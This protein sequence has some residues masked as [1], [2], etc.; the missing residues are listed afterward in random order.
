MSPEEIHETKVLL[1]DVLGWGVPPQYLLDLGLTPLCIA[2]CFAELK[3]RLPDNLVG[4]IEDPI[5]NPPPPIPFEPQQLHFT[6]ES[7]SPQAPS[8]SPTTPIH[9]RLTPLSPT[10][11]IPNTTSHTS[12]P[13]APNK[14]PTIDLHEIETLRKQ[15]LLARRAVIQSRSKKQPT[16]PPPAPSEEELDMLI[17]DAIRINGNGAASEAKADATDDVE[18]NATPVE[19]PDA[20]E[21]DEVIAVDTKSSPEDWVAPNNEITGLLS[22]TS[23][24]STA[25][26]PSTVLHVSAQSSDGQPLQYP[27]AAPSSWGSMSDRK[28]IV[29]RG[30]KRPVAADFVDS[31]DPPSRPSST[32][33]GV[34]KPSVPS[35][36]APFLKRHRSFVPD[37]P[38]RIVIDVSED[39]DSDH[40][41]PTLRAGT[42]DPDARNG[43]ESSSTSN[44]PTL[45]KKAELEKKELEIRK[46]MERISE[47]ERKK[48]KLNGS[49]VA[50]SA[51]DSGASTPL[52]ASIV[53]LFEVLPVPCPTPLFASVTPVAVKEEEQSSSFSFNYVAPNGEK[54]P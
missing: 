36:S 42:A 7:Q 45:D 34:G 41:E 38:K 22:R 2:I 1:L 52:P 15:E 43:S 23:S 47:I 8:A 39:D 20:M 48:K 29:K 18:V 33:P 28:S 25:P 24:L 37:M 14:R 46:M 51:L 5:P 31:D 32:A 10:P 49:T 50:S 17:A 53:P 9:P 11:Q 4:L 54:L 26:S 13:P 16:M 21:V 27:A 6:S 44:G 12:P 3:L 30:L 19:S 35:F 40:E